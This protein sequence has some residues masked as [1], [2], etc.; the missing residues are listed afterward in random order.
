MD[1]RGCLTYRK[2][3]YPIANYLNE[4]KYSFNWI[5]F[6]NSDGHESWKE[7]G[8]HYAYYQPNYYF[9]DN[10]PLTRLDEACKEAL[11]CNMQMEM[12]F[13]DDVDSSRQSLSFGKLYGKIQGVWC[14]GKMP[15]GLLSEQ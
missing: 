14:M 15:L 3:H 7:L 2:Y 13:E 6:F 8:F 4:L 1:C 10:I 9:D 11:R 12:E 5:P